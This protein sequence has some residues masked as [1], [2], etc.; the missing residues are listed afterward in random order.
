MRSFLVAASCA[1]FLTCGPSIA[2][3]QTT[4]PCSAESSLKSS[5]GNQINVTFTNGTSGV[6]SINWLNYQGMRV[7][8]FD[9]HPGQS[10]TQITYI[11]H[12]WIAIDKASSSCLGI[13][14]FDATG[15]TAVITSTPTA[16]QPALQV[17]TENLAFAASDGGAPPGSQSFTV[18]SIDGQ[19]VQFAVATDG[20]QSNTPAPPWLHVSPSGG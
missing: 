13:W 12:P 15:E 9:L 4:Y 7:F 17:S 2:T 11:T 19:A 20:G 18:S 1:L 5:V 10:Q 6:V 8:Y 16:S 14:R 3:A